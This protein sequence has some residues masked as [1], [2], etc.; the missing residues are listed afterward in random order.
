MK[1]ITK[2]K[3][4]KKLDEIIEG[5]T[6]HEDPTSV[7]FLEEI[8][9]NSSLDCI[10]EMT[11]RALVRKNMNDSIRVVVAHEG[12]GINDMSKLV[13]MR[14]IGELISLEDKSVADEVLQDVIENNP[15][16]QVQNNARAVRTLLALS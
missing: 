15:N 1:D 8:G 7:W 11:S 2:N 14:T 13:A 3:T 6:N 4:F 10:R 5:L 9:S 12:K 16:E